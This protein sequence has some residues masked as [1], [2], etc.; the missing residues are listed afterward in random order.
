M[1]KLSKNQIKA[2]TSG[3]RSNDSSSELEALL[4]SPVTDP[5]A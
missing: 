3:D 4:M 5:L 1:D 2:L